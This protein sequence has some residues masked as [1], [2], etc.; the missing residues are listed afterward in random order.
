VPNWLSFEDITLTL[1][2]YPN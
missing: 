1:S 2:G